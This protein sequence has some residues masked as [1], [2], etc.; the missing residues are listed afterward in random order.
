MKQ[1][2]TLKGLL[3][4]PFHRQDFSYFVY[5]RRQKRDIQAG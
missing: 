4:P 3:K 5:E 2:T 1:A